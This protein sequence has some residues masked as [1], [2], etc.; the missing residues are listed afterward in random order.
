[1]SEEEK[2][3]G[4]KAKRRNKMIEGKDGRRESGGKGDKVKDDSKEGEEKT[5]K[6]LK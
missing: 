4:D 6:Q 2:K 1:M 5:D 3:P